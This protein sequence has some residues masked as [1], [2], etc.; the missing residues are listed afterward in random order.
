MSPINPKAKARF[1]ELFARLGPRRAEAAQAVGVPSVA[2]CGKY[3]TLLQSGN[4]GRR[5]GPVKPA[6]ELQTSRLRSS[7][8]GHRADGPR[9]EAER[10]RPTSRA[11]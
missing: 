2:F 1:A 11:R 10:V 4:R 3:D 8:A 9:P 5:R 7:G 6:F